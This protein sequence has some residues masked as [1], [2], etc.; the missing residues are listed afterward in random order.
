LRP[1]EL[2]SFFDDGRFAEPQAPLAPISQV[3]AQ[4]VDVILQ[5]MQVAMQGTQLGP[6]AVRGVV[7]T[8]AVRDDHQVVFGD[9]AVSQA[10]LVEQEL[11]PGL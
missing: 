3:I 1:L 11:Q 10:N 7:L 2:G 9:D 8:L 6:D 5:I 4:L